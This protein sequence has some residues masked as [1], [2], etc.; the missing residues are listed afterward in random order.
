MRSTEPVETRSAEESLWQQLSGDAYDN[1]V[2]EN[3]M[4]LNIFRQEVSRAAEV[5]SE[6]PTLIEVGCGT[7]QFL[8]PMVSH[9]AHVVG[10][11]LSATFLQRAAASLNGSGR[12]TLIHGDAGDLSSVLADTFGKPYLISGPSRLI[13]CVMNTL[14]I[15]P[16]SSRQRV[17][18]EM[19]SIRRPSDSVFCVLFDR[20]YLADAVDSF[21]K[22]NPGLCGL[23]GS[24][25]VD[26]NRGDLRVASSG[27][28][29]HWFNVEEV[30]NLM[31]TAGIKDFVIKKVGWSLF[32]GAGRIASAL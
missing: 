9:F 22:Q 3:R 17:I 12:A 11:D 14:G 29:S 19:G 13:C 20:G 26:L 25:D 8:R 18:A 6:I 24:T 32:V 27:Y 16:E 30:E 21:Y 7:G 2:Y 28:Y 23:I 15:M 1:A 10:I 5:A 31:A 4:L